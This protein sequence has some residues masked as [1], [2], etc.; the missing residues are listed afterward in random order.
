MSLDIRKGD[1][2]KAT[3]KKYPE[4][5]ATGRVEQVIPVAVVTERFY[6]DADLYDFEVLERPVDPELLDGAIAAYRK[7]SGFDSPLDDYDRETYRES[8]TPVIEFINEYHNKE[9]K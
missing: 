6:L 2:I 7:A 1:L 4:E 5:T 9:S 3:Y 8:F